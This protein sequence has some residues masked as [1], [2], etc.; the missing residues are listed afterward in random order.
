MTQRFFCGALAEQ[1]PLSIKAVP[2][3]R[4]GYV[5][6]AERKTASQLPAQI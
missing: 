5:A 6:M 3:N 4:K 2:H 1:Q